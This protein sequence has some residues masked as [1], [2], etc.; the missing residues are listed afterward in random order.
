MSPVLNRGR[1]DAACV[2]EGGSGNPGPFLQPA[3]GVFFVGLGPLIPWIIAWEG[4]APMLPEE[5]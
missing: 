4:V 5:D 2:V 1:F 3:R